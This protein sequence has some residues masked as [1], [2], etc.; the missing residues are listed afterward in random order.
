MRPATILLLVIFVEGCGPSA[1]ELELDRVRQETQS[2]AS[3]LATQKEESKGLQQ[4]LNASQVKLNQ[5]NEVLDR[6]WEFEIVATVSAES[7]TYTEDSESVAY[8]NSIVLRSSTGGAEMRLESTVDLPPSVVRVADDRVEVSFRYV[9]KDGRLTP[10]RI[11][12]LQSFDELV[13]RHGEVMRG[14]GLVP[15]QLV[16]LSA[17]INGVETRRLETPFRKSVEQGELPV[18]EVRPLFENAFE[19]F[20][21]G[22]SN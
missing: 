11:T 18:F 13:G 5:L 14:M 16:R 21:K 12:S 1:T 2:L 4:E 3:Q 22:A 7:T 10:N 8:M 20:L 17:Y 19:D 6:I 9:L 15:D